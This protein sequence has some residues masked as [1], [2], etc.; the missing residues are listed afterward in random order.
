MFKITIPYTLNLDLGNSP[1]VVTDVLD[2]GI[3]VSEFE[4]QLSYYIHF[5]T[6]TLG[7]DMNS[8]IQQLWGYWNH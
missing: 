5:L 8:L 4:L 6:N 2:R 1:D 7:I 3:G